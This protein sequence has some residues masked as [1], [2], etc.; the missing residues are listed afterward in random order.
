MPIYI[1]SSALTKLV[2]TEAESRR[3]S[4]WIRDSVSDLVSS[5]LARAELLRAV[6]RFAPQSVLKAR[7]VLTS[8]TFVD[9]S[10]SIIEAA[11][12]LDPPA[13]R[14]LD[15]IHLATA[16]ELE[17]D[18]EGIVTYDARLT[19]AALLHAVQVIAPA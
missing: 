11:W 12:R 16:L 9:I 15:A 5:E 13:L 14:T 6:R 4:Q 17:S 1:D 7:W 2:V 8:V 18:L 19:N 3:L 10:G